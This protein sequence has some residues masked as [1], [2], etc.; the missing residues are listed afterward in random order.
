MNIK[1]E[2]IK[3]SLC[4]FCESTYTEYDDTTFDG[5]EVTQ[6]GTCLSC[7]KQWYAIYRLADFEEKL[8]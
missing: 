4:P 1:L 6:Q 8:P 5:A 7:E 3:D 2:L